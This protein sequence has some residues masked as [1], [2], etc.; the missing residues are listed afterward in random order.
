MKEKFTGKARYSFPNGAEYEGEFVNDVPEGIGTLVLPNFDTYEGHWLNGEM[1][2]FGIYRFYNVK[3]DKLK[4][5][6]EGEFAHSKFNGL[7]K[8]IYPDSSVFYGRW[9]DGKKDGQ[10][11][12]TT[13]TGAS[14]VGRWEEDILKEG[15][16][17]YPDGTR[18]FGSFKDSKFNGFGILILSDGTVQQGIWENNVIIDG[19][20]NGN[21]NE[22][23]QILNN[24]VLMTKNED[25]ES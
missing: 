14:I 10:G 9:K 21:N 25:R 12:Y 24:Q 22:I 15:L 23:Y 6:Y 3:L 7:G 18:Y 17:I 20:S 8:M 5:S 11:Q 2:G 4:G 16:Y 19:F 13:S 1:S